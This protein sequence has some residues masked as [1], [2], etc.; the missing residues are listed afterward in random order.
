MKNYSGIV[1][2][3]TFVFID[4][5]GAEYVGD[6][7]KR[8]T[9]DLNEGQF[10]NESL[11]ALKECIRAISVKKQHIPFRNSKLTQILKQ[12]LQAK[13]SKTLMIN[14]LSSSN[15]HKIHSK[16]TLQYA[17]LVTKTN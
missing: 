17:E 1:L 12:Y 14:T 9:K 11:L 13:N 8:K 10:I 3:G 16:N 6:M 2:G 15:Q 5:A 7:T 4:L